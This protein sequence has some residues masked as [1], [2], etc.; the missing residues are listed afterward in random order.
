LRRERLQACGERQAVSYNPEQVHAAAQS[1]HKW[2][3]TWR[4]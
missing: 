1:C 4:P 2:A 3:A